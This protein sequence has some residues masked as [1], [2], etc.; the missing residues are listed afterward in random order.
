[1]ARDKV[2]KGLVKQD[3]SKSKNRAYPYQALN[4]TAC[5]VLAGTMSLPEKQEGKNL[6]VNQHG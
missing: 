3:I 5:W 4:V 2:L 1:M 6:E